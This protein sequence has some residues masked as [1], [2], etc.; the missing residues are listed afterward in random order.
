MKQKRMKEEIGRIMKKRIWTLLLCICLTLLP[1]CVGVEQF[2]RNDAKDSETGLLEV[3]F[4]DVGQGDSTLLICDGEAMLIDAGNND[5]GTKI[6]NYL[7]KQGVKKLKYMIGT[8]PDADHIGGMDVVLYKFDCD[9][10][11]MPS[12][13]KD[14]AT[15]RDVIDTMK[16]KGYQNTLPQVGKEYTLG[17]A[18]F[19]ILSPGKEYDNSNDNS[20]AIRVL[21]GK[22]SFLFTGD[23]EEEAEEDMLR[24]GLVLKADVYKAGHHG[25]RTASSEKFMKTVS[26]KY[27]VISCKEGNSYGHPHAATMN[28]FRAMGIDVFRTDEQGTIVAKCDKETITFNASPSDTWKAGEPTGTG[29]KQNHIKNE[30]QE[31]LQGKEEKRNSSYIC[32]TNTM[33][34]HLESCQ[35]VQNMKKENKQEVFTNREELINQGYKPCGTCNP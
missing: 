35:S 7:T 32:N 31:N 15:Y 26:P 25:S 4:I 33:K 27:A 23:G 20:I 19:T 28:T 34:F 21:Y 17:E 29:K 30:K 2:Q 22:K 10:I 14:T 24:S 6:Q 5:Q 9:T 11:L 12:E 13:A 16:N 18:V 3:H 8:H 1:S